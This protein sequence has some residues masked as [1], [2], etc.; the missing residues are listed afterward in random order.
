MRRLFVMMISAVVAGM[1]FV[2]CQQDL[3]I[4]RPPQFIKPLMFTL[5]DPKTVVFNNQNNIKEVTSC[6]VGDTVTVYLRTE[7][8][9]TYIYKTVYEWTS[10][11]DLLG[12]KTINQ[13]APC[14]LDSLPP[15][16]TFVAP[17]VPGEYNIFFRASFK[18]SAQTEKGEI[19]GFY[20]ASS[21]A[22]G[23]LGESSVYGTLIVE[24]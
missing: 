12:T 16:W 11:S 7:Y 17:D 19:Y 20:P 10:S 13:I 4:S 1:T 14:E 23:Y 15:K 6:K 8:T 21:G 3:P 5:D 2:S 22:H 24:Q 18:Y 9:G